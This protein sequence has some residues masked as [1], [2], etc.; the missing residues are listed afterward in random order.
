[1]SKRSILIT[2]CSSGIGRDAALELH[3][4]GWLVIATCRQKDDCEAL[5]RQGLTAFRLDYTDSSTIRAAFEEAMA[6]TDGRLD[7]DDSRR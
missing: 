6:L 4:R 5:R 7:V 3:R 2:G 1:M